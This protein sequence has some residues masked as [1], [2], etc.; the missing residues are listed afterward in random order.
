[1]MAQAGEDYVFING[2]SERPV[3]MILFYLA[4]AWMLGTVAADL[5]A[6]PLSPWVAG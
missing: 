4:M 2:Q 1:M 6:L 3:A 5:L